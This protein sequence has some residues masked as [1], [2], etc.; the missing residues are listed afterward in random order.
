M[1]N[2]EIIALGTGSAFT[3]KNWQTNLI[4]RRNGKNL[5]IDCGSDIRWSLKDQGL[6]FMDIDAVYISHA[7]ADHLGGMEFLGFTRYFTRKYMLDARRRGDNSSEPLALPTLYCARELVRD[8]WDHSLRG[9]MEGLE[10]VDADIDTYFNVHP[11]LKNGSFTWQ[12]LRFDMVQS[13]HISAKYCIVDSFGLMFTDKNKKRIYITT[14]VQFAPETAMKAYYNESDVILHDCE[15]LYHS[16]VHAHYDSLR[17]LK[18]QVKAKMRL[19]HYQDNVV[20]NWETWQT[21]AKED[22]FYGFVRPGVIYRTDE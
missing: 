18:P 9:G 7:H 14:D 17:T 3:M 20:E 2:T 15:T 4:V 12:G 11:V 10:G 21:K 5:L 16:G 13:L 6:S 8:V 22:G 19:L 1:N